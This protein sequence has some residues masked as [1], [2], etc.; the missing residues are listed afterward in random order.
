[1]LLYKTDFVNSESSNKLYYKMERCMKIIYIGR[2]DKLAEAFIEKM[3]KEGNDIYFLSQQD[4]TGKFPAILQHRFYKLSS[5]KDIIS[6]TI[7]SIAPDHIVFAGNYVMDSRFEYDDEEELI[8]LSKVLEC[9]A[10]VLKGKFVYLSSC[11]VYENS[12]E[13]ATEES[14]KLP[15]TDRGMLYEKGE[16]SV[17]LYRQRYGLNAVIVRVSQL[18]SNNCESSLTD[19]LSIIFKEVSTLE[20]GMIE[21]KKLQPLHIQDF[22]EALKRVIESGKNSIYN[23]C[24]S[25]EVTNIEIAGE[26]SKIKNKEISISEN[27]NVQTAL[28]D[29]SLIKKELEW[30]DFNHILNLLQKGEINYEELKPKIQKRKKKRISSIARRLIEHIFIFILFII[31]YYVCD[32]HSLFSKV[33]WLLIYVTL[34][35][36]IFGLRQSA[37]AVLL[38][39]IAY[40]YNQDLSIFEMNN[41]YSYAESVLMI[42][43]FVF[44]GLSI[45]YT[46]DMLKEELRNTKR[47]M[48]MLEEEHKE[49][50]EI[51]NENVLI[52]NEYEKR[53]LDSKSSIPKLY[54][55]V[56][57]IMVQQPDRIFFE[58]LQIISELI[59]TNTVA[60]YMINDGSSY[61]RLINALNDESVVGGKSWD[62]SSYPNIQKAINEGEIY[63]GDIWEGEPSVIIP[64]TVQNKCRAVIVV[65]ELFYGNQTLYEMNLL[66]TMLLLL[67]QSL[68]RALEYE[69]LTKNSRYIE[70]TG[71]LRPK[72]FNKM[73]R[74]AKEKAGKN[75]ADYCIMEMIFQGDLQQAYDVAA[76]KFRLTDYLG[77]DG[78]GKLFVLLGNTKIEEIENLRARLSQSGIE[79]L[80]SHDFDEI[81]V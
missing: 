10:S 5:N 81:G 49:L 58:I 71:I 28:M 65:K 70:G 4:F 35:S 51:N 19:F 24:G 26:I 29:N 66:R 16:H 79:S 1:M 25:F 37:L 72:E 63:Q 50:K 62:I 54:D 45:S 48:K 18:Y 74:L 42:V 69:I 77:T 56:S 59:N 41:F 61:L 78:H 53:I 60:V 11:E 27:G 22:A 36:L 15:M 14:K 73:I 12:S 80:I 7:S 13:F 76:S 68:E 21:N 6:K 31:V 64:I 3:N 67:S 39:S 34:V 33:D 46:S 47:G 44:F 17:N 57:R 38:A 52:K 2:K 40:L 20:S 55:L 8:L 9:T 43:E 75:A 23:M 30:T 32:S